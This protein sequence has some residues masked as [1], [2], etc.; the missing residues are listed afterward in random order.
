VCVSSVVQSVTV[1]CVSNAVQSV[2]VVCVSSVVESV[3]VVCVSSVVQS[4]TVVCVSS[5]VQSVTV[6][7][8]SSVVESVTQIS[9]DRFSKNIQIPNLKKIRPVGAEVLHA[10]RHD[11]ADSRFAQFLE[12]TKKCYEYRTS[13][14][15]VLARSLECQSHACA[16]SP[17]ALCAYFPL[18]RNT[19]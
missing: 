19:T 7:C 10:V 16:N 17:I 9:V 2:T 8:V 4:V 5:V 13:L 1:V 15:A 11:E 3:T 18:L 6:V 14:T 12:P